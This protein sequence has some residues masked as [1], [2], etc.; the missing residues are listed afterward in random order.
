MQ[1]RS[2]LLIFALLIMAKLMSDLNATL[3]TLVYESDDIKLNKLK[4]FIVIMLFVFHLFTIFLV[5]MIMIGVLRW[6]LAKVRRR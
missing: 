3:D 4:E 2:G 1:G 6:E 5:M